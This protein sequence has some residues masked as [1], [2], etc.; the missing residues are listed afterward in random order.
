MTIEKSGQCGINNSAYITSIELAERLGIMYQF[1]KMVPSIDQIT[2]SLPIQVWCVSCVFHRT[3]VFHRSLTIRSRRRSYLKY[4]DLQITTE[5][6]LDLLSAGDSVYSRE[7]SLEILGTP[8][9]SWLIC[10]GTPVKTCWKFFRRNYFQYDLLRPWILCHVIW[11]TH[12]IEYTLG[13]RIHTIYSA[14]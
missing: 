14:I 1:P 10:T 6:M 12:V 3:Y 11:Y 7:N 13:H 9:T 4:L 2:H 8:V 5:I